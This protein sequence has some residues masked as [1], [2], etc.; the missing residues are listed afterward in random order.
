M[1]K[2]ITKM[3]YFVLFNTSKFCIGKT[4]AFFYQDETP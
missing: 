1:N 4:S 2:F 3:N